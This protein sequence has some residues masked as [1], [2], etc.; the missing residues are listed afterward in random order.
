MWQGMEAHG[1]RVS[2][3]L[4]PEEPSMQPAIAALMGDRKKDLGG[5]FLASEA[6]GQLIASMGGPETSGRK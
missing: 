4:F 1:Y 2:K 3:P 6:C 5:Q